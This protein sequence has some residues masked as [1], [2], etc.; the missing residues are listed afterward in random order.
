MLDFPIH[1]LSLEITEATAMSDFEVARPIFEKVKSL[2]A[3]F[4]LDD[5]ST[6][7]SGLRGLLMLRFDALKIDKI[8]IQ[9]MINEQEGQDIVAA[10]IHLCRDLGLTSVAEG[11]EQQDQADLLRGLGCE[12]GQGWLFGR[13]MPQTH[14]TKALAKG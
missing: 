9:A 2:G 7:Y 6:G 4:A 3:R 12:I 1:R 5:F 14:V 10:I 13:P 11:V 8:F